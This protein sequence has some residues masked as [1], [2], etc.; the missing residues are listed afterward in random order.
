M[1]R[2]YGWR[3]I[4]VLPDVIAFAWFAPMREL[5]PIVRRQHIRHNSRVVSAAGNTSLS[6]CPLGPTALSQTR[7]FK[8]VCV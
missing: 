2:D 6:A 8:R 7:S 1:Y 4:S 5:A 3:G